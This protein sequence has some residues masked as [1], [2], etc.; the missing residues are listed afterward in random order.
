MKR[1]PSN[2]QQPAVPKQQ[3]VRQ[4]QW[5]PIKTAPRDGTWFIAVCAGDYI[6][7]II[8][9]KHDGWQ[10]DEDDDSVGPDMWEL[11]FWLPLSVLPPSPAA[12]NGKRI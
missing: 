1:K 8:R 4:S 6:P 9:W 11:A 12:T 3:I 5:K 10:Q 2:S 7:A